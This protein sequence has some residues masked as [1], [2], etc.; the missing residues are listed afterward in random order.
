MSIPLRE[1]RVFD[2]PR[3]PQV[4]VVDEAFA[5]RYWPDGSAVGRRLSHGPVFN[6]AQAATIVGVVGSVKQHDL[7]D[8]DALGTVYYPYATYN[9]RN[10][11][12]L[13]RSAL[14][15]AALGPALRATVRH[16]D[17]ESP[18]DDLKPMQ[19][20]CAS[21]RASSHAGRQ[22]FLLRSLRVWRCYSHPSVPTVC[23]PSV[24]SSGDARLA[25][26]WR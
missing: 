26:A 22:R 24:W 18:I 5:R 2:D 12:V 20:R 8:I 21:T 19:C 23:S 10:V 13:V 3:E 1:G 14:E 11:A 9:S 15:P 7:S 16:L 17:A 4:C 25:C 6:A